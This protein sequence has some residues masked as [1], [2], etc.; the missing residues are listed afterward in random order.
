M[1]IEALKVDIHDILNQIT[2]FWQEDRHGGFRTSGLRRRGDVATPHGDKYPLVNIM[3]ESCLAGVT[4]RYETVWT[5]SNIFPVKRLRSKLEI[6]HD[7]RGNAKT[8]CKGLEHISIREYWRYEL[9][10]HTWGLDMS[11]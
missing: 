7:I 2:I 6:M 9:K 10:R 1:E 4:S 11:W 8:L 5:N 3:L